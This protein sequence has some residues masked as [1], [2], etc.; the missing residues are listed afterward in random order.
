MDRFQAEMA[1]RG[2]TLA[3][4]GD[5]AAILTPG[6]YAGIEVHKWQFGGRPS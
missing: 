4:D 6:H 3:D 1:A 5:T 2:P